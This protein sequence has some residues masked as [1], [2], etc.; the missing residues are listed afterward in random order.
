MI[1]E[2]FIEIQAAGLYCKYGNFYLDSQ[3]PVAKVV[4]SHAHADHAVSGNKQVWCTPA[5]A[6]FMQHRYKKFAAEEFLL[7]DYNEHTQIGDVKITFISAG[8]ILGSAQILMEYKGI[9]YLY[10]GD[11]KLQKDATCEAYH[12]AKADVLITETTFADPDTIHPDPGIEILKLNNE[13]F[14]IMLG[15]Y[16]LG[17]SQTIIQLI[18][19][20]CPSKKILLHHSIMPFAKIYESYGVKLGDYAMYDRKSMKQNNQGFVYMVPPMVFNSYFRAINVKRAFATGWK[21]KQEGNDLQLYISDH[22]DWNGILET[23]E[24][25]EPKQVWTLHGD[26]TKLQNY[27]SGKIDVKILN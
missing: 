20:C 6:T 17:K 18:N 11:Y 26:G 21:K 22:A 23:I 7:F 1:L 16:A 8:H 12:F 25:T 19:Q 13:P 27:L 10:T 14:N 15:A 24:K 5:T 2:D 4:I 9:K 3:L